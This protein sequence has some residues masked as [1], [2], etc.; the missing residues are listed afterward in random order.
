MSYTYTDM[1]THIVYIY[2]Y[3]YKYIHD[4]TYMYKRYA[5]HLLPFDCL[6]PPRLAAG[7]EAVRGAWRDGRPHHEGHCRHREARGERGEGRW[8]W[9]MLSSINYSNM[10]GKRRWEKTPETKIRLVCLLRFCMFC[11]KLNK[12]AV[13]THV[14]VVGFRG[15][16]G[17]WQVRKTQVSQKTTAQTQRLIFLIEQK[18]I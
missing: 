14:F 1:C 13:D 6:L 7:P 9:E 12:S 5:I 15:T 16:T 18:T 4:C 17:K 10:K 2:I 11:K 8:G 3:T